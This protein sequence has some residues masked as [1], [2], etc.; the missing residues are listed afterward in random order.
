MDPR[1]R[2][3]RQRVYLVPSDLGEL[4]GPATGVVELPTWLDWSE[5]RVYDLSDSSDLVLMY[6]RVIREAV[7]FDDL[8]TYLNR[9]TLIRIWPRL[10]LP[11]EARQ[12]WETSFPTLRRVA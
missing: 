6:E 8:R 9:E 2:Y 10:Y 1:P 4:I 3:A 7:H 5:Q 11:I 12:A